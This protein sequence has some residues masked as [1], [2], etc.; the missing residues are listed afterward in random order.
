LK[1]SAQLYLK[2]Q[3]GRKNLR[4][5]DADWR[6]TFKWIVKKLNVWDGVK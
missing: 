6:I 5:P 2:N 4:E 1:I 3:K